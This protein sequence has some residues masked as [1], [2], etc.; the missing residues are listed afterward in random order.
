MQNAVEQSTVVQSTV[1]KRREVL[2]RLPAIT[3]KSIEQEVIILHVHVTLPCR[4][5]SQD[6]NGVNRLK[7]ADCSCNSPDS[8]SHTR[9]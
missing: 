7:L 4:N 3:E 8:A 9:F 6:H 1:V 5:D 2:L